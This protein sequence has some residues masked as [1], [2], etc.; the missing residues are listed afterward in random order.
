MKKIRYVAL[1]G[2]S[3]GYIALLGALGALSLCGFWAAWTMFQNG[4]HVTGMTNSV[5]WGFPIVVA[6]YLVGLSAGSLVISALSSVFGKDDF[7]PFSRIAAL[8][9]ALLL[10]GAL[11]SIILDWGRPERIM[12]PFFHMN[13]RSM[14]SLNG[15][16]YS[17]Y[18]AICFVYLWAMFKENE[19]LVK[20]LGLLAVFWAVLVH[21]GTGAIFGFV[22][23]RELYHSPLLPPSFIAAALS[24][25]TAL[26]I[27]VLYLT[28]KWAGKTLD[29]NLL[30]QLGG[31]LT[32]FLVVVAYLIL[33]ENLTRSYWPA[34]YAAQDFLL[35]SGNKYSLIFWVGMVGCGIVFPMMILFG[36]SA[37]PLA[38]TLFASALVVA[39]VLAERYIIVIPGQVLPVDIFPGM[40]VVS[41]FQDGVIAEYSVSSA[42]AI[43]GLGIV[44]FVFFLYAVALKF[45]ELMPETEPSKREDA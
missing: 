30:K 15:M 19:K 10:I 21:S 39:G 38:R 6:I 27:L 16:L 43:Y 32:I 25:G 20:R 18:V 22:G 12:V 5:P 17:A 14:F 29:E 28:F 35:F 7:K 40:K 41:D 13:P 3:G 11:M 26:M 45:F 36:S 34:N 1:E 9:A 37:R 23:A 24:S 33:V 31:H 8:L 42:E 4:H 2:T 44:S